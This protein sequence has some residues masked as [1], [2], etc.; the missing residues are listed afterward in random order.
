MVCTASADILVISQYCIDLLVPAIAA[1][2]SFPDD[3]AAEAHRLRLALVS[4]L[5][6]GVS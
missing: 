4:T 1:A 2:S 3:E 6:L 5:P